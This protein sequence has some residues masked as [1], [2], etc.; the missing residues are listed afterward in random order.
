MEPV[1]LLARSHLPASVHSLGHEGTVP[2][3]DHDD[4]DERN[5]E[6]RQRRV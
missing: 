3:L 4:V 5:L 1:G 6:P 2:A